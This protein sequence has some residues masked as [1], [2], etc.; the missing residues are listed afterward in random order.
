MRR[1]THAQKLTPTPGGGGAKRCS[2]CKSKTWRIAWDAGSRTWHCERIVTAEPEPK[3]KRPAG[4]QRAGSRPPTRDRT[5][6]IDPSAGPLLC[7]RCERVL[8]ARALP[9]VSAYCE[10]CRRWSGDVD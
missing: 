1:Q 2:M 6:D 7:S 4:P 3:P 10:K 8:V 5:P 9:G